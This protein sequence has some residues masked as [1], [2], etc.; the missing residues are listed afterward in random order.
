MTEPHPAEHIMLKSLSFLAAL[1]GFGAGTTPPIVDRTN[2]GTDARATGR[3]DS[4]NRLDEPTPDNLSDKKAAR[5]AI[6][7]YLAQQ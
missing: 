3:P 4:D 7:C 6:E 1:V 5:F 2:D